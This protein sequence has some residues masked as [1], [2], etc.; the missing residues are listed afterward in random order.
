MA[1]A[2]DRLASVQR[3]F[4]T[5]RLRKAEAD[6]GPSND[7]IVARKTAGTAGGSLS[8]ASGRPRDPMWYWKH[9]NLPYNIWDDQT[10]EEMR[11][12]R[13]FC[14]TPD[15][16]VWMGDFSFKEIGQIVAGDEVIGWDRYETGH[17]QGTQQKTRLVR[18]KVLAVNR[19]IAPMI[20]KVTME[21]GRVI[22][23]TPDHK[24]AN[25][26]YSPTDQRAQ[27]FVMPGL[28]GWRKPGHGSS[29]R[30]V[31][32][33]TPELSSEKERLAAAWLG[34]L[35]D[36]EGHQERLAQS[37]GVNG[38]VC[39]R[40]R[41][42]LDL[43]GI[44]Y[45][46][47]MASGSDCVLF[48]IGSG[49]D[50]SRGKRGAGSA[51]RQD[52]VNFINWCD[53]VRRTRDALAE[54]LLTSNYGQQD[55]IV[56]IEEEGPG[57]VVSMQ[58]ET[59]NYT[60]WGYA[61]SNCRLLYVTHPLLGSAVDIYSKYPIAGMEVVCG[62]DKAIASFYSELFMDD[63][64]YE[65]FLG[66]VGR[67]HWLVGEAL[68]LASFNDLSGTWDSDALMLPEDVNVIKTPFSTNPRF[69]MALPWDIRQILNARAPRLEYRQL[70]EN[71]PEFLAFNYSEWTTNGADSR[72]MIPV[73]D[74]LMHQVMRKGDSFHPRGIPILMRA[75]RAVAQEE[76]LNAA[77]DSI[78][79]RLYTPLILARIGASATDLGTDTPWIPTQGDLNDFVDD[80]NMALS[81]DFRLIV[82]HFAVNMQ[83]VFGR[84]AMPDLSSDFNR[85]EDKMLQAFGM[86]KT[87]L[88]GAAGGETYAADAINR[89]LVTQLLMEYQRKV[90]RFFRR[91]CEIV[92]EAQ[93]H[94][95]YET[96]GGR[97]IP[98]MERIAV[99][100][101]ETGDVRFEER[102]KLLLP[103]LRIK[104]MNMNDEKQLQS[105]LAQM[106]ADGV[107]ISQ[108]TRL[109]NVPIDLDAEAEATAQEQIEQAVMAQQV[110]RR[111]YQRLRAEG[112]PIPEDLVK[113]FTP[114]ILEGTSAVSTEQ[115]DGPPAAPTLGTQDPASTEALAP[116]EDPADGDAPPERR[117]RAEERTAPGEQSSRP[118]ESD[119]QRGD[120]PKAA[121][122]RRHNIDPSL[123]Q[124]TS[125]R[126]MVSSGETASEK[127][128]EMPVIGSYKLRHVGR[129]HE[130]FFFRNADI[131]DDQDRIVMGNRA[132]LDSD[133]LDEPELADG[134]TD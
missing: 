26:N 24:W 23:C 28:P 118:P 133:W 2:E 115:I 20:V 85:L 114:H 12:V 81:A 49:G 36:G 79:Q 95:D 75:F 68:P 25:Y 104:A 52:L 90:R 47:N 9:T 87:M 33:P 101:P 48:S 96:K 107:P 40:I 13:E 100:D 97:S 113:D 45:T 15:A 78:S 31:I 103:E 41:L 99:T 71:Y 59:G 64:N 80:V 63:L 93:G 88:S 53:P 21:S 3:M 61:S 19:R 72:F 11:K 89:D 58:T 43:L 69:E 122:L 128:I 1:D 5:A 73:S 17:R 32:D 67:E 60:A 124:T 42:S 131:V 132:H 119:E 57:E 94:Y 77:Q 34:G 130:D 8:M 82:S 66:D 18:T 127:M 29:L 110:R 51:S 116:T 86:S 84:E 10:G 129:R 98:I 126:R 112:L 14:N 92:A 30:R 106:R 91:R 6:G 111:T 35:Y 121:E 134:I 62:K 39:D 22:R 44:S 76:M 16:P 38:D 37:A 54:R 102:P 46:A 7:E 83:N 74:G 70:V 4:S 105:L 108:S 117:N 120:M 65:E 125:V 109:V 27:E 56:S 55:S 123:I 50:V